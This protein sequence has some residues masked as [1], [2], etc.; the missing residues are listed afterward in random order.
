MRTRILILLLVIQ[1]LLVGLGSWAQIAG[2][3]VWLLVMLVVLCTTAGA[4][5]VMQAELDRSARPFAEEVKVLKAL[6][7][8]PA[9]GSPGSADAP[10]S[11]AESE[12]ILQHRIAQLEAEMRLLCPPEGRQNPPH[13]LPARAAVFNAD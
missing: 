3:T 7:K 8:P 1:C 12:K 6:L 2:G 4:R 13:G 9:A 10:S 11:H 5:L